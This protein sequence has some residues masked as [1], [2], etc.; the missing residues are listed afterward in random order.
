MEALEPTAG[1]VPEN[2]HPT[3]E[4]A[5]VLLSSRDADLSFLNPESF[6]EWSAIHA[7]RC[8]PKGRQRTCL[9]PGE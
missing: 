4:R 3:A 9:P 7:K 8:E 1:S 2:A 5:R 6:S